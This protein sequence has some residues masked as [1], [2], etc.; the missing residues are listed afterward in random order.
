[1][2]III[3]TMKTVKIML[4]LFHNYDNL[5]DIDIQYIF[6]NGYTFEM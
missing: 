1:M 6:I 5:N 2:A 3:G 4:N